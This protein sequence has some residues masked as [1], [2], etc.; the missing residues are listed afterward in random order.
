MTHLAQIKETRD[1]IHHQILQKKSHVEKNKNN[2]ARCFNS[3]AKC[4][5][6]G[7]ELKQHR[8]MLAVIVKTVQVDSEELKKCEKK[9]SKF[10]KQM[11]VL[12]KEYTD[13]KEHMQDED[14]YKRRWCLHIKGKNEGAAL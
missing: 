11:K 9:V 2:S 6:L 10:E 12:T 4:T 13:P 1:A 3:F 8:V 7:C 14:R 5:H